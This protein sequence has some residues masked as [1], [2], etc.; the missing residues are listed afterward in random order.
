MHLAFKRNLIFSLMNV[1]LG[2]ESS[3]LAHTGLKT[4]HHYSC[5]QPMFKQ[6]KTPTENLPSP[7]S[8]PPRFNSLQPIRVTNESFK[9]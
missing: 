5:A 9:F 2:A 3:F 1:N 6:A 8:L 7:I 4:S